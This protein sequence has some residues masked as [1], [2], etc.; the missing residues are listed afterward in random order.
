MKYQLTHSVDIL[1]YF[2]LLK[3]HK[4]DFP[5]NRLKS[6]SGEQCLWV[7]DHLADEALKSKNFS[8]K[9]LV[10]IALFIYFLII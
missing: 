3:G 8:W 1:I 6:G 4:G 2:L 9:R 5:P 7:L 10:V